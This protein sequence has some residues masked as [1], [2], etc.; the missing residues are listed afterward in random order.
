MN[1]G[2]LQCVQSRTGTRT[3]TSWIRAA[4]R[5]G[6]SATS[7]PA[8]EATDTSSDTTTSRTATETR[9]SRH[10]RRLT[11]HVVVKDIS[12]TMRRY[13]TIADLTSLA[14]PHSFARWL[15]DARLREVVDAHSV[16]ALRQC[17]CEAC[18]FVNLENDF[19]AHE[20]RVLSP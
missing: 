13:R 2:H 16:M 14:S 15:F 7:M 5:S 8:N 10:A 17:F 4:T 9:K 11:V 6:K 1:I 18:L 19:A 20:M 12:R 3:A